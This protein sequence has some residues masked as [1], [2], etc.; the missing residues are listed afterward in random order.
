MIKLNLILLCV[1]SLSGCGLAGGVN[2]IGGSLDQLNARNSYVKTS[3]Q[4]KQCLSENPSAVKKCENIKLMMDADERTLSQ[5]S[6]SH[7]LGAN[8]NVNKN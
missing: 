7:G 1:L 5:V 3:E 4:Y 2:Y 6:A 8:V